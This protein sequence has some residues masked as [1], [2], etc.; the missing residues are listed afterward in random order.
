MF[1]SN[2]IFQ[3][4][5]VKEEMERLLEKYPNGIDDFVEAPVAS[6]GNGD[7]NGHADGHTNG[8]DG[9]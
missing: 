9:N 8:V 2:A 1:G 5:R 4:E 7:T 6:H 3:L